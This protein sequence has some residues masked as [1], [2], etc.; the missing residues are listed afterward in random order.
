M[1]D[2]SV[3]PRP[4]P[5]AISRPTIGGLSLLLIV[6]MAFGT[7]ARTEHLALV[8]SAI[9]GFG[10]RAI[11]PSVPATAARRSAPDK[12]M[13][14]RP[15]QLGQ[16]Y[17]ASFSGTPRAVEAGVSTLGVLSALVLDLP[18]P[19]RSTPDGSGVMLPVPSQIR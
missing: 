17:R 6:A 18:P 1:R 13:A 3:N 12:P 5:R 14:A 7:S 15:V 16:T 11:S 10:E 8:A 19:S 2:R 9:D 4:S